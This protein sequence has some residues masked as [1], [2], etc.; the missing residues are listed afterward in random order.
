MLIG[1]LDVIIL[2]S[3]GLIVCLGVTLLIDGIVEAV[4]DFIDRSFGD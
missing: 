4:V 2:G 3:C 1:L